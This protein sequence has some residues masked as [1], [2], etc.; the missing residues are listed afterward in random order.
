ME[1]VPVK[2]T[3]DLTAQTE[4]PA[5][6]LLA[7]ASG[8]SK[9][10]IKD[11]MA[12]GACWWSQKGKQVRLRKA[13]RLLKPGT[14]IQLFYDDHVLA[15]KPQAPEL[16]EDKGRYS[17]WHKPHGLLSQGSQWGDHCSLLRLAETEL[18]RPC[19]LVHRL[20]G[21]AAGLMLV[22]H[23]SK[24]AGAL[25]ALFSGRE[26]TKVYRARVTG[27]LNANNQTVDAELDGKPSI[28]R[29]TTLATDSE[30]NTTTVSVR[31][32]TGRKHQ[33]RRHL[34]GIGHPI[35]GDRLYGKVDKTGLQLEAMYLAFHC[36]LTRAPQAF[37]TQP[38]A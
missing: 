13:K 29:V 35:I 15:R 6:D 27:I 33:I 32:E 26:V 4:Q 20:D 1:T 22:A 23:D 12:R 14:R 17:V 3:L 10:R 18:N 30:T 38:T 37:G 2:K 34:A 5:V 8:L 9:Q 24:A 11:A 25:S 31:I 36:P 28:S 19:Y 16:V 21:D 7:E